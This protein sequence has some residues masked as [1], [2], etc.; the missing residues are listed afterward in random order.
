MRVRTLMLQKDRY[1]EV[2]L[3]VKSLVAKAAFTPRQSASS[4]ERLANQ[5]LHFGCA[6]SRVS[7]PV[8]PLSLDRWL[9]MTKSVV[10]SARVVYISTVTNSVNSLDQK[11]WKIG[12]NC[13]R[14]ES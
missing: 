3:N 6:G 9:K 8:S 12:D 14:K 11:K 1:V 13:S 7:A 5:R 2:L 10:S 4:V